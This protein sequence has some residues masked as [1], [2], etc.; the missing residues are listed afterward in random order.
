MVVTKRWNALSLAIR[1]VANSAEI[2]MLLKILGSKAEVDKDKRSTVKLGDRG[3]NGLNVEIWKVVAIVSCKDEQGSKGTHRGVEGTALDYSSCYWL[4]IT[5]V[6][7]QLLS[8]EMSVDIK[9][10]I[11]H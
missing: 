1:A 3:T 10:A 9:S 4:Y 2:F 11:T 6:L 8:V 7:H 5:W